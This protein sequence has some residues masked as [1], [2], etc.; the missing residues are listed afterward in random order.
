[1]TIWQKA[2]MWFLALTIVG[3]L[4]VVVVNQR[5]LA[6]MQQD[7]NSQ[8]ITSKTL[9]E[10]ISRSSTNYVSMSDFYQLAKNNQINLEIIQADL[11]K[12]NGSLTALS[13]VKASSVKQVETGVSGTKIQKP[14]TPE[15]AASVDTDIN[16]WYDN[17]A[18]LE[19]SEKFTGTDKNGKPVIVSV[20]SA[21]VSF[22]AA[23]QKPWSYE[24]HPREYLVSSIIATTPDREK[25][26]EYST[27]TIKSDNK[28][29]VVPVNSQVSQ[30]YPSPSF[31]FN[32]S[33]FLGVGAGV[34]SN[35]GL[36]P[37]GGATLAVGLFSYGK[38]RVRPEL[39]ILQV[40]LG[41]GS[42]GKEPY[43]SV[44]PVAY[45]LNS[46][47][48]LLKNTYVSGSLGISF[49]GNILGTLDLKVEL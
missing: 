1:M 33:L 16:R 31:S 36:S 4:A 13:S 37:E 17:V 41:Y 21:D 23:N 26:V 27:M 46:V 42:I 28:T 15:E 11:D 24:V 22:D 19:L 39:S 20:P 47:A 48:P 7:L 5:N 2:L 8:I 9:E 49:Q 43:V 29:Y 6:K 10:L 34:S 25:I 45:N 12:I 40:G 38:Y 44:S 18:S 32:P 14:Q 30:I 35:G 3:L